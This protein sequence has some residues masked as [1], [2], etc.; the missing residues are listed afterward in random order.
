VAEIDAALDW[1]AAN[2]PAHGITG[3]VVL[4]GWSARPFD[5]AM[6]LATPAVSAGLSI[7]GVFELGADPRHLSR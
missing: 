6:S 3:K 4:S 5:G 7:S 2:G 1:L